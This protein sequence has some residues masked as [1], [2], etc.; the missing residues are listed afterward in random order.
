M[1]VQQITHDVHII[2]E[3]EAEGATNPVFGQDL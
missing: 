3:I 1:E 2:K